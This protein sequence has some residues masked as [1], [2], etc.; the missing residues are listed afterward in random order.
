MGWGYCNSSPARGREAQ[1]LGRWGGGHTQHVG[2]SDLRTRPL[3]PPHYH[4]ARHPEERHPGQRPCI[5]SPCHSHPPFLGTRYGLSVLQGPRT[6]PPGGCPTGVPSAA[7]ALTERDD[8]DTGECLTTEP[9]PALSYSN[10]THSAVPG[11][12]IGR[13]RLSGLGRPPGPSQDSAL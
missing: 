2:G 13:G 12:A 7:L 10:S 1:G 9:R 8:G 3:S 4:L 6:T 11:T 5:H